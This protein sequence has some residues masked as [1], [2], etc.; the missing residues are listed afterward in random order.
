M[1]SAKQVSNILAR[2]FSGGESVLSPKASFI[3]VK[4]SYVEGGSPDPVVLSGSIIENDAVDITWSIKDYNNA[5]LI[6]DTS[7]NTSPTFTIV[8]PPTSVGV[9]TYTLYINYKN[10]LGESQPA[11]TKLATVTVST[12]AYVGKLSGPGI[13]ISIPA[14]LTTA[15][16]ATLTSVTSS[17]L[18]NPF[19]ISDDVTARVVIVVPDSYGVVSAIED[20][21][22]TN[23]LVAGQFNT[24]YDSAN[25]RN[26]YVSNETLSIANWRY[27]VIFV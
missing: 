22:D 13:N 21:T 11:I 3:A 6:S 7:G 15:I 27:K 5:T 8:S 20:N 10:E 1:I 14:D 23:V 24:I 12:P 26:I 4:S 2:S 9:Y 16:E 18:I 19:I 25:F 17:Q